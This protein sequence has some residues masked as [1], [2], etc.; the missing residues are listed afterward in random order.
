MKQKNKK[1]III[2]MTYMNIADELGLSID[3]RNELVDLLNEKFTDDEPMA[4]CEHSIRV[5]KC[6]GVKS[7]DGCDD[8][9]WW[10][11]YRAK[12]KALKTQYAESN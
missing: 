8:A 5:Q 4:I 7:M 2:F 1:S 10:L 12:L 11:H 9:W 6:L 3:K